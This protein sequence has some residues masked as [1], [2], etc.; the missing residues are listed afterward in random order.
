MHPGQTFDVTTTAS[1]K[2]DSSTEESTKARVRRFITDREAKSLSDP[3]R[4]SECRK[5][6]DFIIRRAH[7]CRHCRRSVCGSCSRDRWKEQRVC[8]TCFDLL[9]NVSRQVMNKTE[10]L[11][12]G[13][14]DTQTPLVYIE[15]SSDM[16][17]VMQP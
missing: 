8:A 14:D 12:R 3:I 15:E 2:S 6:Y 17:L 7:H 1:E 9:D 4:C 5:E 10:K 11:L 13:E 16:N